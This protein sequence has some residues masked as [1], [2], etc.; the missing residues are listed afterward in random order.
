MWEQIR[1]NKLRSLFLIS[2]LGALL[3][4]LGLVIGL[5]VDPRFGPFGAIIGLVI[6][7]VLWMVAMFGGRDI[8][9]ASAH[10]HPIEKADSPR[11]FNVVDEMTIAAGLPKP[12]QIFIVDSDAPN[13]FSVG[14]PENSAVGVTTGLLMY[15]NRDELQGVIGHEIGHIKNNDSRFMTQ[16]GVMLAAIVILADAYLR[17]TRGLGAGTRRSSGRGGGAQIVLVLLAVVFALLAPLLAQL[18]YFACSR[19]REYLADACSAQ[20]TRYP[21]G[22]AS[23]LEKIAHAAALMP[24][25]NR[26]TAPMYI[27]NPLKGSAAES[28]FSTHPPTETRIHVL[29]SMAGGAAYDNYERAYEKVQGRSLMDGVTVAEGRAA[30]LRAANAEAEPSPAQRARETVD[31]MHRLAGFLFL[32][33]PCGMKIKVPPSFQENEIHCPSCGRALALPKAVQAAAGVFAALGSSPQASG[34]PQPMTLN[35]AREEPPLT[36]AYTPGQW[37]SFRC[38]CGRTVQLSPSLAATQIPCPGCGR[39]TMIER[40]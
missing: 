35:A 40:R 19:K 25:V 38:S 24:D 26:A 36:Y 39:I 34:E 32:V 28:L 8:L 1:A 33:C 20:Y 6:W 31:I 17:A 27:V 4:L 14:T 9:L 15:M 5:S 12:P 22:L 29:R 37:Q 11:L 30:A 23:A 13:A 2:A 3:I 7:F 10:A 16:A 18:L 21:E